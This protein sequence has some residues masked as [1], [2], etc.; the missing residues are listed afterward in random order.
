MEVNRRG[1]LAAAAAAVAAPAPERNGLPP[2]GTDRE[3]LFRRCTACQACVAACPEG[4]LV[5][6]LGEYGL[7]GVMMPRQSFVHGFCR[8]ECTVCGAVCPTGAIRPFRV[9]DK[10]KLTGG[11][12]V[13]APAECLVTR[14][15]LT[16]GNCAAHCPHKAIALK[17]K[18]SVPPTVDAAKC[19][20]CGACEYH[21]PSKAIRVRPRAKMD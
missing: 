6:A 12:A 5:A 4:V 8:P 1:F 21:C 14:E 16:C 7:K 17:A 13:V 11:L 3:R 2:P 15:K 19:V 20:G 10:S 18:E 9:E